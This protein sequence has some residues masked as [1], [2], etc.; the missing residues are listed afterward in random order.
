VKGAANNSIPA[1]HLALMDDEKRRSV[2]NATTA[3][4]QKR[5][6][7]MFAAGNE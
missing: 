6:T 2:N 1:A 7:M 3:T 4:F 5:L